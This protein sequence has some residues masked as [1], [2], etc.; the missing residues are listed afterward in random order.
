MFNMCIKLGGARC[1][2]S[3]SAVVIIGKTCELERFAIE[4]MGT[5]SEL[6]MVV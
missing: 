6:K 1:A 5:E 2:G 3:E 4:A